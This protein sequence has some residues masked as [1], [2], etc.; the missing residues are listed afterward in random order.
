MFH[1]IWI[2]MMAVLY[3]E[4]KFWERSK[5]HGI[6]EIGLDRDLGHIDCYPPLILTRSV[7]STVSS[8]HW[9]WIFSSAQLLLNA[10]V[11]FTVFICLIL[12]DGHKNSKR[13]RDTYNYYS[14]CYRWQ[15]WGPDSGR[16]WAIPI[17]PPLRK[18]ITHSMQML[19]KKQLPKLDH[20]LK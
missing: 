2:N 20:F 19:K 6:V 11:Q 3:L 5:L 16:D 10:T 14:P 7:F 8:S 12:F 17:K 18:K 15:S 9:A 13:N 1:Q 4:D